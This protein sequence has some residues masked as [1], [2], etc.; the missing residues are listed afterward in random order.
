[1]AVAVLLRTDFHFNEV[2]WFQALLLTLLLIELQVGVGK[3]RG[4]YSGEARYGTFDELGALSITMT[5][6]TSV[7]FIANVLWLR[8][9][10]PASAPLI[11]GFVAT[12]LMFGIRY[13]VRLSFEQRLR[14]TDE[15]AEPVLVFGAGEGGDQLIT[16]MIRNPASPFVPV[17]ILDDD[18][19]KA[20]LRLR[21]VR[22]LGDRQAM[23]EV[24]ERTG[25]KMLVIAVPSAPAPLVREL[26]ELAAAASLEVR[27]LPPVHELLG[28]RVSVADVR[29]VTE[30]DLLGRH[31]IDTDVASVAGYLTDRVV[32]V[33]GAGGSIGSELCRQIQQFAPARLVMLDRD[34]SALHALQLSL[35]GR[36]LLDT[37]NLVVAD[38]RDAPRLHDVFAACRP[39]VVFHAAALKHLPLLE[40]HPSEAWKTNVV[41]TQNVLDAA[42]AV[43]CARFVN[44]STDKAADPISALG[45][46][47][48]I[49]ERLT[50]FA[51]EGNE[52]VYLSV[53]F[54]NVLGSRG[55][56]LTAFEQ[57]IANGGPVTVTDP[58][59]T[60]FF[61][62]IE[63]ACQLVVQ[64]GA[65]GRSGEA[66]VLDMGDPVR[67]ADFAK[68]LIDASGAAGI[69]IEYTGL[70]AG[71]KLHESLFGN[72]EVDDRPFHPLVSHT[73]VPVLEPGALGNTPADDAAARDALRASSSPSIQSRLSR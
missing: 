73:P 28:G 20:M 48:R 5:V 30:A 14:P 43:G 41:G 34:E 10:T 13:V 19:R 58:D 29:P 69:A 33:T 2:R 71:E 17:G 18:P 4:L 72:G 47:K 56:V 1:M 16:T 23:G 39:D 7:G 3:W 22:V 49:G 27:I 44:I 50:A 64:A 31:E 62:T 57:Q 66:L 35:E 6:V 42:L 59:V 68:R 40:L 70:R 52:G 60:R 15:H 26:T 25:A 12:A 53:R 65:I 11:G 37:D 67:I 46:S 38:I 63:E 21:G 55:S 54:G 24:A 61:M 45:Y 32:L 9:L 36:A 8:R 51:G